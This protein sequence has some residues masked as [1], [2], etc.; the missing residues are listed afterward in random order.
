MLAGM[1]PHEFRFRVRYAETDQMGVV[2]HANYLPWMEM[3][4]VELFRSLG[5]RYKDMEAAGVVMAVVDVNVRYKAPALYDDEIIVRTS[6]AESNARLCVF[7][8]EIRNAE[9]GKLLAV[10]STRHVFLDKQLRPTKAPEPYRSVFE[11]RR[12]M[13]VA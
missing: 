4:R 7:H 5:H 13:P 1:E 11:Q 6:L 9:T 10:G 8:Y 3:G 12:E 2:Y